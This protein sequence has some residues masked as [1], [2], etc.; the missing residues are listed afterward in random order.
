MALDK[1]FE[2]FIIY[3]ASFN[4]VPEI[5]IDRE[6]QIASLL[7][8]KVKF[9]DKYTDFVDVFSKKKALVLTERTKLNEYI[10]DQ[11]DNK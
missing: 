1:N 9:L 5:Y 7:T 11:K 8:K 4:L 10:I 6:V 3:M 2:T